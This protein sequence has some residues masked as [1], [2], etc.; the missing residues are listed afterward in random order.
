M[1][2]YVMLYC[3][4][5]RGLVAVFSFSVWV[6]LFFYYAS[7]LHTISAC[8]V[9][10]LAKYRNIY[11]S[12]RETVMYKMPCLCWRHDLL[13][14]SNLRDMTHVTWT[15]LTFFFKIFKRR[16]NIFSKKKEFECFFLLPL[17]RALQC[18]VN[19]VTTTQLSY[20][21]WIRKYT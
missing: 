7:S 15:F 19:M 10:L 4:K 5:W 9:G 6:L 17:Y 20:S 11:C 1:V 14:F 13:V 21:I 3:S 16:E 8:I 18:S 2:N 12:T